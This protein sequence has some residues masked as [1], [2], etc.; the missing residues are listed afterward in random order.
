MIIPRLGL[1][2][3]L[4]MRFDDFSDLG[5]RVCPQM[6][7]YA[8]DGGHI[9]VKCGDFL[10]NAAVPRALPRNKKPREDGEQKRR[11][12]QKN[13]VNLLCE[14]CNKIVQENKAGEYGRGKVF[15]NTIVHRIK[16]FF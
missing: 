13:L 5:L 1:K 9:S 16:K 14:K 2:N 3:F 4:V 8:I 12:R 11:D 15:Q 10:P 6:P 7:R